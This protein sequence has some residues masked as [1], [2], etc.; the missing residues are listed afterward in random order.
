M[1]RIIAVL[2]G[3]IMLISFIGCG[4]TQKPNNS[5]LAVKEECL[6]E[7]RPTDG[8]NRVFYE[9]FVSSFSDSDG[10]GTGDI[11]GI[12][13]RM[14]YLIDG[15]P[16]SGR[17]LGVEGLWLTPIFSSP[18]Y[19]KY[20][21]TDYYTVDSAF[22][23]EADLKELIDLC[24][25]RDVW[26]ILDLPINHTGRLNSWFGSFCEAHRKGDIGSEYYDLYSWYDGET[27]SAPAGRTFNIIS[28]TKHYYECNF[29]GD[30]PEL[31]FD[32]EL[33]RSL[34]VDVAKHYIDLGVDGF[35]FD[36]AKYVYFND[37]DA[38]VDFWLW[39]MGKLRE[40]KPD[41]Y[42]VAEVWDG[43]GVTDRYYPATDCFNFSISEASGLIAETAKKGDVNRYTSY[44]ESYLKRVGAMR[45]GAT[46]TPFITNHDMD[47]AAGFLTVA[48]GFMKIAANLYIL[49]PGTPF[50]Y[51][52]EELGMRGSRG[53]SNTDANRRLA[54]LW[55]DGDTVK[56]PT[57]TTYDEKNQID[58]TAAQQ[59]L[60]ENSL[61]TYYKRLI[62]IRKAFPEI[63]SGEYRSLGLSGTKVGG[64]IAEKD[65]S[66]VV[67]IHN[68]TGSAQTIDLSATDAAFVSR[69]CAVIG[70]ED[71]TLEGSVLT[72]GSMTSVVLK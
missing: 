22:G 63:A 29:S 35:R 47:R 3:L 36:A 43:D 72:I 5:E 56:N 33:A 55:G 25:K 57:G 68:T 38:S 49:G 2:L 8:K 20:D 66:I 58:T 28:G 32:S 44:I 9:I 10:D 41:I 51:Y 46:L 54:M 45:D 13:S 60:D 40:L 31:N 7:S 67:V 14:D 18:S 1:K 24:H 26:V 50:I 6:S 34:V 4:E 16:K 48:S 59:L 61:Y 65:G 37:H 69:L 39:Y 11:R 53:G 21:I 42:S 23:T 70:V 19:H 30:M 64:F 15:D 12:I 27:E 17:S 52:G 71:A 62:I